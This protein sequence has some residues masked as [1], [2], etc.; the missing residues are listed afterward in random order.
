MHRLNPLL[1][2]NIFHYNYPYLVSVSNNIRQELSSFI[3]HKAVVD[4]KLRCFQNTRKR[5]SWFSIKD[6]QDLLNRFNVV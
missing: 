5:Q 6:R 3:R 2:L 4:V 1:H